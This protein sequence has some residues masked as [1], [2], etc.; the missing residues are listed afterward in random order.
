MCFCY[1]GEG[2]S[3]RHRVRTADALLAPSPWGEGWGEGSFAGDRVHQKRS[4]QD[5]RR[6][7][8]FNTPGLG[9][10][11]EKSALNDQN[12]HGGIE[13]FCSQKRLLSPDGEALK[14][15][16]PPVGEG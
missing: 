16:S 12:G 9:W 3:P 7:Q 2:H 10:G 4:E 6:G 11:D 1:S 8:V 13:C 15:P 14:V 5:K